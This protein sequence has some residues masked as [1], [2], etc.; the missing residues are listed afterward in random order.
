MSGD[1]IQTYTGSFTFDDDSISCIHLN[2][3]ARSL[4]HICRF[5]GHCESFYS[6]A[7]HSVHCSEIVPPE[8][9]LE[10]L[11]HDAAEAYIGDISRPLKELFKRETGCLVRVE[12]NIMRRI[13]RKFDL[14]MD[15]AHVA[16]KRADNVML[17]TEKRD[18]FSTELPWKGM[19]SPLPWHIEPWTSDEAFVAFMERFRELG[20]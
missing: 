1:W 7:Q 14:D 6:V 20:G 15:R 12:A 13:A 4:S 19:L 9:A 3:I 10:A 8:F 18:L 16:V 5:T 11:M 2:D 17:A